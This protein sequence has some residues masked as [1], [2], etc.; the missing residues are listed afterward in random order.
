MTRVP[1]YYRQQ[2]AGPDLILIHGLFGAADNLGMISRAFMDDFRVLSLD[3]RNHG[4][5][6]HVDDM[7][8]PEMAADVLA[9]LEAA[10]ITNAHIF[11]HSMGG[12]VAMELAVTAPER[13]ASLIIGDIA[14]VTYDHHHEVV[15][16]A[17][18]RAA[19]C[20]A[21]GRPDAREELNKT[22]LEPM[23]TEF[24]LTNWRKDREGRWGWRLNLQSIKKNYAKIAAATAKGLYTGPVLMLRGAQS[25]YVQS[26]H[27]AAILERFSKVEARAIEGTGH[28]FHAEKPDMT[29]RILRRFL[30]AHA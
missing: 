28:W 11:G 25:D 27:R 8:Y 21:G 17:M 4:R 10:N 23:V 22:I 9:V 15:L 3:L 14:P 6:P 13:V 26:H 24:L 1:L 19:D 16:A 29:N 12:K 2:G 20:I 18:Q 7:S 5:S 30:E